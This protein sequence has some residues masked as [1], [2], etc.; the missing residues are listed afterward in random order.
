MKLVLSLA[1]VGVLLVLA[2]LGN[3]AMMATSAVGIAVAVWLTRAARLRTQL[4]A[5]VVGALAASLAAEG[6]HTLYHLLGGETASGDSG[7]FFVSAFLVGLINA[8]A[9]LVVVAGAHALSRPASR[10][11]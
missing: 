8:A 3:S 7:F 9:M 5:V 4:G 11:G 1:G 6:V 10:D 2:A